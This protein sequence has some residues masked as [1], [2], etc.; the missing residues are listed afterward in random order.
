MPVDPVDSIYGLL[1]IMQAADERA[2]KFKDKI[3][4][5]DISSSDVA[6]SI[7]HIFTDNKE[8]VRENETN[9]ANYLKDLE[10]RNYNE[11]ML[12]DQRQYDSPAA[13]LN[14]LMSTG[15][16]RQAA[17]ELIKGGV[18]STQALTA[19]EGSP[20]VA[21]G[22]G[23]QKA[24]ANAQLGLGIASTVVSTIASIAS[25]GI[26]APAAIASAGL[27]AAGALAAKRANEAQEASA[28]FNAAVFEE[29]QSN[30]DFDPSTMSFD[31][32]AQHMAQNDKYAPMVRSLHSSPGA[33]R[34]ASENYNTRFSNTDVR[35]QVRRS[36]AALQ[37]EELQPK[38]ITQQIA[39]L[40]AEI[41]KT[42]AEIE[43]ISLDNDFSKDTYDMKL[44]QFSNATDM[45]SE[46]AEQSRLTTDSLGYEVGSAKARLSMINIAAKR[47]Q[48]TAD[49]MDA[50]AVAECARKLK[51]AL[52]ENTPEA[53][54]NACDEILDNSYYSRALAAFNVMRANNLQSIVGS[55][56]GSQLLELD[57][58]LNTL[59]LGEYFKIRYQSLMDVQNLPERG[60]I[61]YYTTKKNSAGYLVQTFGIDLSK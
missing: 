43:S 31:Q 27:T 42:F 29:Q 61:G 13:Y 54:K 23:A 15:L 49:D 28:A 58:L 40:K 24:A 44:L 16:S 57:N 34:I 60:S 55:P 21:S 47:M 53:I 1:Y 10:Q 30:P 56:Q 45:S 36:L 7:L 12:S 59:N 52:A 11:R 8:D 46:Q 4:S 17:L 18:P 2:N 3:D 26:A 33:Y 9:F 6:G 37:A 19:P 32:V 5:G 48:L 14:R 22:I 20:V 38:L 39:G 25:F 41:D 51:L 50:T 35:T